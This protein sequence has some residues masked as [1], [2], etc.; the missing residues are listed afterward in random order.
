M[1]LMYICAFLCASILVSN[2]KMMS[3]CDVGGK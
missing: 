3:C 1:M 2:R